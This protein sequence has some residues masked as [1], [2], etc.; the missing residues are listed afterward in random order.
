MCVCVCVYTCV[1]KILCAYV[2]VCVSVY[3]CLVSALVRL[4]VCVCGVC[5]LA[6]NRVCRGWG[7]GGRGVVDGVRGGGVVDE[8]GVE[9]TK[10]DTIYHSTC[11][12]STIIKTTVY[13]ASRMNPVIHV[14]C[15]HWFIWPVL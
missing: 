3:R 12:V 8:V 15:M 4:C 2:R 14:S 1:R 7:G 10:G 5:T 6:L 9:G 13:V 11:N